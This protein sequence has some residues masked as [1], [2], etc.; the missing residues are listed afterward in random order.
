MSDNDSKELMLELSGRRFSTGFAVFFFAFGIAAGLLMAFAGLGFLQDSAGVIAGVFL[1]AVLAVALAGA[2]V[3]A[4]RH[5]IMARIFGITEAQVELFAGPLSD[6][7]E[8]AAVRDPVRAVQSARRLIQLALARYAWLATRRWIMTSLT[9]LIA[10]MAAFA[11]T[12]LLFKQNA[13]IEAQLVLLA[14][15]NDRIGHQN[16]LLDR[17]TRLSELQIELVE[18][19]RNA[20]LALE[21]N[22]IAALLGAAAEAAAV[23]LPGAD[24]AADGVA[25]L[26][27]VIDPA[28]DL[29]RSTMFRIVA[30]SQG[31]RPYRFLEQ[32]AGALDPRQRVQRA[33]RARS[34]DL[35]ALW[36]R[37]S[38]QADWTD[39]PDGP[40]LIDRPVSPE[41]GHLLRVMVQSGLRDLDLLNHFG[42]DLGD[43]H[44]PGLDLLLVSARQ[45]RL[46]GADLSR[47]HLRAVDLAGAVLDNMRLRESVL[48]EVRLAAGAGTTVPGDLPP[49]TMVG[50]DLSGALIV[51]SDLSG[52]EG[53]AADFAG[54]TLVRVNLSGASLGAARMQGAVLAGV[55]LAGADLRSVDLDGAIVFGVDPLAEL[56]QVAAAG[57]FRADRYRAEPLDPDQVLT[58][59]RLWEVVGEAELFAATG[60]ATAWRLTRIQPL[61][62]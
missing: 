61:E 32:G 57:S 26:I 56:D 42:L 62:G 39:A 8:G 21:V 9:A 5:R 2:L 3:F 13:L 22:A 40:V 31:M 60:G 43:A 33:L 19:A 55:N 27:P 30:L 35:P 20:E 16:L 36:A 50:I 47:S 11:G 51:D 10:A 53:L 17:Q 7:A 6:V 58:E 15:Q 41:R 54:A 4:L 48:R 49:A 28:R 44:A 18:A 37:V 23:V 12:A 1:L 46:A 52:V 45:A 24:D 29:P 59:G 14:E 34:G 25:G 38:A